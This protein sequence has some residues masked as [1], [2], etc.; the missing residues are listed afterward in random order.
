MLAARQVPTRGLFVLFT[1]FD[2]VSGL[3]R[4]LPALQG[5]ARRHVLL[6]VLFENAELTRATERPVRT[7][8]EAYFET[9]ATG[10]ALEKRRMVQELNRLGIRAIL[11]RLETLTVNAINA[12]LALKRQ[13]EI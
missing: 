13:G 12:Y 7:V 1:N 5:L 3:Q 9:V 6:V 2:T 11:S 10:F 4:H 8:E